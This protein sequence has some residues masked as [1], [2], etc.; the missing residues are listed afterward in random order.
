MKNDFLCIFFF[1]FFLSLSVEPVAKAYPVLQY[2]WLRFLFYASYAMLCYL[3]LS[4]YAI[5]I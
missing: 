3:A 5:A 2:G 4:A 1:F